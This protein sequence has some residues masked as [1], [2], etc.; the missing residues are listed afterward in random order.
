MGGQERTKAETAVS[1]GTPLRTETPPQGTPPEV[2]PD[3]AAGAEF[4]RL[5]GIMA[6][7]RGPQG[8]PW[9]REQTLESLRGFVL[10]ETYEVLD[11][12][13]RA[14]HDA[15]RGEIG[16]LLFEGVFLAQI[17]SDEGRFTVEDSLRAI[18]EKLIRRHPHIFGDGSS[19]AST[20][21]EVLE[22]WEQIKS[23]EQGDAGERRSIL[24]G[25]PK[26]LPSL[27]RAHEIGSRVAAV[28]FDWVRTEDVVSKI[29]EEVAE[30]RRAVGTEGP[31]RTEEEIG[32][33]LFAIANLARRLGVEPESALRKANEKFSARFEAVER[34][35]EARG[36]SVHDSSLEEM[37][38]EWERIKR[39]HSPL[40]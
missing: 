2:T 27:L 35:L 37:D 5:A 13:D 34:A 38:A 39:G 28:G 31:A 32:D 6:R 24:R 36:R 29:E 20:P 8:C 14:D 12:I 15:L 21:G 9:D 33:L 25:V 26:A 3:P 18:N 11:A 7:L 4:A 19:T 40:A 17:E 10:E 23:R 30:V 16:D 22:Q 1:G